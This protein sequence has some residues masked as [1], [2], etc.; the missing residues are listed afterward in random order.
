M[1]PLQYLVIGFEGNRFTGEILP[2]LAAL[3]DQGIIRVVDL[4]LLQKDDV[5]DVTARE[6]SDLAGAEGQAFGPIAGDL[7]GLLTDEDLLTAAA[8][9]PTN[10]SA[11]ILLLEHAWAVRLKE[12]ILKANGALLDERLIPAAT[13][14]AL[15]AELSGAQSSAE[16]H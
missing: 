12:K 10:S 5:G 1:G 13:I 9:I 7:L 6:V 11:A 8:S 3:R 14:E 16:L 15:G 2:E 4:L